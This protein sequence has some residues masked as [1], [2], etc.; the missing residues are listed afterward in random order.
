MN[1]FTFSGRLARDA[2]TRYT[3]S[4][5]AITNFTV[6]NDVGYGDKKKTNWI[7]CAMF[8][9]RGE[10]V[11]QYLTKGGTVVVSGELTLNEYQDKEGT[12]RASMEVVVREVDLPIRQND[13]PQN[14][15]SK[16][17][18]PPHSVEPFDDD[19]PF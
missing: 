17:S 2:E 15:R 11:A 4:G 16:Q 9:Q 5:T 14:D 3:P 18:V 8:G 13:R 6:A 7:R 19:I 10:K 1:V 12:H